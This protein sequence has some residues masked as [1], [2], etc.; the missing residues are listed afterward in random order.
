MSRVSELLT[1]SLAASEEDVR[2]LL[3]FLPVLYPDGHSWLTKAL[4][5]VACGDAEAIEIRNADRLVG[6]LLGK[7]K[8]NRYKVRTLFVAPDYRGRGLGRV[9]LQRGIDAARASSASFVYLTVADTMSEE[10]APLMKS[11]GFSQLALER[12]RYGIGRDELV[13]QRKL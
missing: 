3:D 8:G 1:S 2:E 6:I 4:R 13:F 5:E 7:L 10:L 11:E 12:N 9:L